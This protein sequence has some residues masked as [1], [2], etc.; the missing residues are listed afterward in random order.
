MN[1]ISASLYRKIF[2]HALDEGINRD[3]LNDLPIT[4]EDIEDITME[5]V[6]DLISDIKLLHGKP[7]DPTSYV[8]R[9]LF[10]IL[11]IMIFCGR[12]MGV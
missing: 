6:S 5:T 8:F 1:Y 11:Y 4:I 7:F 9:T 12:R 3:A 2:H 10:Q